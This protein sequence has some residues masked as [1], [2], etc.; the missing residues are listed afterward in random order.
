MKKMLKDLKK[1]RDRRV[2]RVSKKLL[3]NNNLEC[4]KKDLEW[5]RTANELIDSEQ[6]PPSR[7]LF[8]VF[9]V[10]CL[11]LAGVVGLVPITSVGIT[12]GIICEVITDNVVLTLSKDWSL[13]ESFPVNQLRVNSIVSFNL[14]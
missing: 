5:I 3:E 8:F 10:L 14:F 9:S 2:E 6:S 13:S 4:S 7:L 12:P 11:V 1:E